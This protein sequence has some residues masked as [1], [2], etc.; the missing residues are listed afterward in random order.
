MKENLN[1]LASDVLTGSVMSCF[2]ICADKDPWEWH[3]W[4]L[5]ILLF[6]CKWCDTDMNSQVTGGFT[7]F[8]RFRIVWCVRRLRVWPIGGSS[9]VGVRGDGD[10]CWGC[11]CVCRILQRQNIKPQQRCCASPPLMLFIGLFIRHTHSFCCV[12][13]SAAW[14]MSSVHVWVHMCDCLSIFWSAWWMS[15]FPTSVCAC[16]FLFV[17]AGAA[18][19]W[20]E[21]AETSK[22]KVERNIQTSCHTNRN[23]FL[24]L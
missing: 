16:V 24:L 2:H 10:Y 8:R 7:C 23:T 12:S 22:Q 13:L 1:V 18:E 6:R 21:S 3:W 11:L 20:D 17:C 9:V 19:K 14:R 15:M 4:Q 5:N